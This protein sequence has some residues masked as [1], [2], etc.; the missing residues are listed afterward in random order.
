MKR[1]LFLLSIMMF[2][3]VAALQAQALSL[4]TLSFP[5]FAY[6]GGTGYFY[7]GGGVELGY[8]LR[9]PTGMLQLGLEYRII[10]W[11]NQ[12][13]LN[14]GYAYPL[15]TGARGELRAGAMLQLGLVPFRQG[16]LFAW[17][18]EPHLQYQYQTQRR[19][20]FQATVGLRYSNSPGYQ[21]I[22]P[23]NRLWEVPIKLG[24]GW[25]LGKVSD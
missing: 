20:F 8:Q 18:G 6:R 19:A 24:V 15:I 25:R 21:D 16:S 12:L 7:G 3:F 17:G 10:D 5:G 14:L 2:A 9:L 22:G 1:I 13:G 23:I 4:Q 11:G